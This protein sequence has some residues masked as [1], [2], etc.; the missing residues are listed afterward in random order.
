MRQTLVYGDV[1]A[2]LAPH[3]ATAIQT[4]PLI[5]GSAALSEFAPETMAGLLMYAPANT[6][7]RR[8]DMALALRALAP[9]SPF[10][11]L[12][13][14]D[15]GGTRLAKEL[16]EFG[17]SAA[18]QPKRHHRICTGVRPTCLRGL[19]EAI[20]NGTMQWVEAAQLYSQPGVFA[21]DR[22]DG[23]SALLRAHV[24]ALQGRGADFGCGSGLLSQ[25]ILQSPRVTAL[26]GIDLDRRATEAARRNV[27]DARFSAIWGDVRTAQLRDLDFVV[28][29]PP[30]HLGGQEDQ[31]LGRAFIAAA[32]K[33]LRKG[34]RLWLVA[35]RHLPYEATL[36]ELF[37]SH[38]TRAQAD[39]FKVFEA[40]L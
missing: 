38:A 21:W 13:P 40:V 19:D 6:L 39:G 22:V 36:D 4:S 15:R 11:I 16:A 17:I 27:S 14:K 2:A 9:Q 37:Q 30:F 28:T 12:A 1:P 29:N 23:G 25:S 20:A 3:D 35:N 33:A 10:T 18:D 34:G 31:A 24:L 26:T 32:A 8:H 7:E 5:L